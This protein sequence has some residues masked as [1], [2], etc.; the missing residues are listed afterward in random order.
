[1]K[2][3][4][5]NDSGG[6]SMSFLKK[7]LLK[8]KLTFLC[9]FL[10]FVQLM[11]NNSF[12]Q[13]TRVTLNLKDTRVEEVLMKIEEQSDLYFIYNRNVVDVNRIVNVSCTDQKITEILNDIFK[14][15]GVT[16]EI[17]DRHIILKSNSEQISQQQK[18][19]SGKVTDSSGTS[20]PGVSVVVKGTTTGVITDVD[21]KYTLLKVPENA[22]LQFSFV[23]MKTQGIAVAG[24]TS[25]NVTLAEDAIGIEEVVAVGYGTT[26]QKKL[27]T[28]ATHFKSE[29]ME[30]LPISNI[31]DAF[32]GQLS[33]VLADNNSGTPGAAPV[34]RIRGYG[35]I[36]AGSEP[37]YVIDGMIA[38]AA[39]FGTLNPKSVESVDVLKDAAAGAI[40][41][42]RA[43][44]GVVIVTT[45]KGKTGQAI[46][47]YNSTFGFQEVTKKVDVLDRN[48]WLSLVKEA[49]SNDKKALPSFYSQDPSS[50]AN[51]NWQDEIFRKSSYQN[52]QLSASG[53][54]DKVKYFLAGNVLDN[55]GII[56]TTYQKNYSSNGNFEI[57]LKQNLQIGLTF[58]ASHIK[59]R[60]N[61][62]I[63]NYFGHSAGAYNVSGGVMQQA[64][65][66]PP[67][68]PVYEANGDY[69]QITQGAF[70]PYFPSGYAN[71]VCNLNETYDVYSRNN[72]MGRTFL[73]YEPI[74]GLNFNLSFS[75]NLSSYNR[76]YYTSP[77]LSGVNSPLANFSNPVYDK[78]SAGQENGN[79]TSTITEGYLD[80]KKT[81]ETDH[82]LD[83]MIG[84]SRQLN[85][86]RSTV[87]TSSSNDRGTS[88]A[89]N[90]IAAY[91]ND[92]LLNIYGAALVLGSGTYGENSFESAFSRINYS[93]KD[94]YIFMGSVR[95]DGSSKF[96]PDGRWG[97]FPAFSA[98]WRASEENFLKNFSWIND[99]KLRASYGISGNDQI[100]NYSWQG[101][102]K[103]SNLYTYA[104]VSDGG[105]GTG[106][107]VEPTSIENSKL[108]WETNTQSDIGIDLS[109]FK[110]RININADYFVRKTKDML[111][112]RALPS[113][114]GITS[115]ILDNVG[116]MS[117]KGIEMALNTIN[118]KTKDFSWTTDFNFTKIRNKVEK[119]FTSTGDIKLSAGAGSGF[120]SAIRI[121]EGHEM[122]E[123]Y[124]YKVLGNFETQ[125]QID[126]Y[127][128]ANNAQ[129][130]DPM[131][132][133]YNKD[134]KINT[135][136]L[137]PVGKAL[138]DFTYGVTNTFK[139]KN[140]DLS[141]LIDGSH[142]ASKV[143]TA[144]RQAALMR[145]AE[146]TLRSFY[147]D[148]YIQGQT[149][150][151][152]AYA[153]TGVTGARHWN[154]SYFIYDASFV[155]VKNVVLGY[156]L[157]K[158]L[159]DK[160]KMDDLRFT[161]GVQNLFTFTK[162]PLWNPQANSND[163]QPGTAQ[164]GVD[165][166]QYPLSRIYT[167]GVNI[168]F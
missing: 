116:N 2:K 38:T 167:L 108:K 7:N 151:H 61:G 134:G 139:Y 168:T 138:P 66:M 72:I 10:S 32:S 94:K 92:Y 119:V 17:Q 79:A 75:G 103:Y 57:N 154:E 84:F 44:N 104:P 105:S 4:S 48:Q 107:L 35:S 36:N 125:E 71:P 47:S 77:Y 149:G 18:S 162:Y 39:Q 93:Y 34:I 106:K 88:N 98:A 120:E 78:V 157:N 145:S 130:G 70:A 133:D 131:I 155:R 140:F 24:K 90:P 5:V 143:V 3:K 22:T 26:S 99:F 56:M 165:L 29:K 33:G 16:Y 127:P 123:I 132:E 52:H 20:L 141:V 89:L 37:L 28:A 42:S 128:R 11:A 76:D 83:L 135:D 74:R 51:T 159:C 50:F 115:S 64:L 144:L 60:V 40:Y 100:G 45:K 161:L 109:I 54:S 46:F 21:G 164:F 148:R 150:H 41:G 124:T 59:E 43:G 15:V 113:E 102:V 13:S 126:T 163:G 91:S 65:W 8:M 142:G 146:N 6:I 81:F 53:G 114:N 49:Y 67:V 85:I 31:A 117:N 118:I 30:S 12:S 160:I 147:D 87:A 156:N 122:F 101:T 166:G 27:T 97:I 23:G 96:A 136:D 58:N 82:K 110:S 63:N 73:N 62:S 86:T 153:S 80:Y 68:V 95:R 121:V 112:N 1:M 55:E 9:L 129:I 25:L 14:G 111:L 158:N 19:I 137:Q 152:F 69:G